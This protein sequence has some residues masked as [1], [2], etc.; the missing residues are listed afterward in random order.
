MNKVVWFAVLLSLAASSL[1]AQALILH[2]DFESYAQVAST[3][4]G[5]GLESA[6]PAGSDVGATYSPGGGVQWIG[7]NPA[8]NGNGSAQVLAGGD[9]AANFNQG[10]LLF[11]GGAQNVQGLRIAYDFYCAGSNGDANEGVRI[12][13][14]DSADSSNGF[15]IRNDRDGTIKINGTDHPSPNAGQDTWQRFSGSFIQAA[16]GLYD[17]AWSI[18]NLETGAEVAAG[19]SLSQA[20]G[21]F[22]DGQSAGL[23]IE[24]ADPS[25]AAGFTG[26][27]DHISVTLETVQA[28]PQPPAGVQAAATNGTQI[29][30]DWL[31][32]PG[33]DSYT[34]YR[35]TL[36][37]TFDAPLQAGVTAPFFTDTTAAPF[38]LYRYAVS[39]V[40]NGLESA[41]STE[42]STLVAS[43]SYDPPNDLN[44]LFIFI[45]DIGWGD[46]SCYGSTVTNKAG[47][48]ITPNLDAIAAAG[49]RF[50]DGYVSAPVCSPSRVSVMTG[51]MPQRFAIHDFLANKSTNDDKKQNDWLQAGTV[52]AARLFNDAGYATG[53]FGKWHMGGGRD[54]D[55]APF[56]QDYGFDESL[57]SFEGMG[58][59]IL[60][61]D[62][63]AT[64]NLSS[65]NADVPGS[66]EWV[67]WE[68][69]ADR[70]TDAAIGFISRAVASNRNFY[71]HV[72]HDD[73]HSPYDTDPGKENDF[74]HITG[75]TTAKLFLSE[76][77]ELDKEIGRLMDALDALGAADNTL[78]VVVGDNG[79]PN[80][81]VTP[82]LSRNGSLTG[83]KWD[84]WEG[85]IREPFFIRCPGIVPAGRVNSGT[86]VSTLDLL[87][88][89]AALA[90]LELPNAPFDGE[91]MS[92]VFT[93]SSRARQRPLFW[94]RAYFSGAINNGAPTLAMRNG[95]Y[96]LLMEPDGSDAQLYHIAT[97]K[98]E[99]INLIADAGLQST[100][101]NMQAQLAAWFHEVV[102]G[103]VDEPVSVTNGAISPGVVISDDYTVTGGNAP[104]PGFDAGDGV[105]YEF[106]SRVSGMAASNLVGYA[107]GGGSRPET[108][109]SITGNRL[110][111][112]P[113]NANARF[114]FSA[115]GATGFDFGSW[116]AGNTYELSVQMD[117][118]AIGSTYAQRM[119]LSLAD[120]AGLVVGSVD[121]GLQV[122][123]DEAG[124]LGV[125]KRID[126]GSHSGGS[127]INAMVASGYPIGT[128]I[129]LKMVV[130]DFN[131]NT[132]DY[133]STYEIFVNGS[134]VDSGAFRFDGS[135]SGRYLIF[136]N[137]AH[138]DV[139]FYDNVKLE[140][141]QVNGGSVTTFYPPSLAFASIDPG[142]IYW[143]A[144]PG[145]V[146]EPQRSSN[147]VDWTSHGRVTNDFGTIQWLETGAG[148][149]AQ[150][151]YRLR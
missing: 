110:S 53:M 70:F 61:L 107:Y 86:A 103:E 9:Q 50:T 71:V 100:V 89:Y 74:D 56:P 15:F 121:L 27:V 94:E 91:D 23:F 42:A 68:I 83:G 65:Q 34:V 130:Q 104:N 39:C 22:A 127:D 113:A 3:S 119:S 69:G 105:N 137:A 112:I 82:L 54:V 66:I 11:A 37:G 58:D 148:E 133:A 139:V 60:Y 7:A 117:V 146:Y 85:G 57:T 30:V 134:S 147:L 126:A 41:L 125:F 111:V 150:Q 40:S 79:A 138:E 63:G 8:A 13:F 120:A 14:R 98:E 52:S 18:T 33:V 80:D 124:G 29:R 115:D 64:H 75:N 47:G 132:V 45:D 129:D 84:L 151:F 51:L 2:A 99:S 142:R 128:P 62:D 118:D 102:L 93:G 131:S 143:N 72:P 76:L 87:P 26:M 81:S 46:L 92:D 21:V 16:P 59:R 5:A 73:T 144:R 78:V 140:V 116:L 67:E 114:E 35:T 97:D 12:G 17:F 88:T 109:F 25:N 28:A 141:M 96:K 122:G 44:I 55:D 1:C 20:A 90:G 49:I 95:D 31:P 36:G 77:H 108:D 24:F 10:V 43:V 19:I 4:A 106:A 149:A 38:T 135:M 101:S 145:S 123:T 32:V 136:D 6:F 48:V